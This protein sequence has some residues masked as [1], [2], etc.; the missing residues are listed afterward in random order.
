MGRGL[1]DEQLD[2]ARDAQRALR[3]V[4][5]VAAGEFVADAADD[6]QRPLVQNLR[7]GAVVGHCKPKNNPSG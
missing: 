4:G 5:E 3:F 7:L 2:L 6:G 1:L